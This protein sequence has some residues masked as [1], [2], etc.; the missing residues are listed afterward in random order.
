MRN[1]NEPKPYCKCYL[2]PDEGKLTKRKGKPATSRSP[3][4][5]DTVSAWVLRWF[6]AHCVGLSSSPTKWISQTSRS[7][8]L[9]IVLN[10][11]DRW[12]SLSQACSSC[13]CLEQCLNCWQPCL[14]CDGNRLVTDR[15]VQEKC[16]WLWFDH[17]VVLASVL[18]PIFSM[19]KINPVPSMRIISRFY[20]FYFLWNLFRFFPMILVSESIMTTT[21]TNEIFRVSVFVILIV[22]TSF[23][24]RMPADRYGRKASEVLSV[25]FNQDSSEWTTTFE[26][27][28]RWTVHR[29]DQYYRFS[30]SSTNT[31]LVFSQAVSSVLPPMVFVS[32][33]SSHWL[34]SVTSVMICESPLL[35]SN[36]KTAVFRPRP[37]HLCRNAPSYQ[38]DCLC[39]CGSCNGSTIERWQGMIISP[40]H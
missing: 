4:F 37:C 35:F 26:K 9:L 27:S 33:T 17:L 21:T 18:P 6:V 3:I 5:N 24:S 15:L 25:R 38:F 8:W 36:R 31:A 39:S 19:T 20:H 32:T 10:L 2:F 28:Q 7:E 11:L 23:R 22:L 14:G 12:C 13:Q 29:I 40:C 34:K 30:L 16:T 1:G